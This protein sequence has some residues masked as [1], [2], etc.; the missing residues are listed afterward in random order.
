MTWWEKLFRPYWRANLAPWLHE[1]QST[2]PIVG[3]YHVY[4]DRGWQRLVQQQ[5]D[6]LRKSGLLE[7]TKQLFVSLV[8]LRE[9]DEAAFRAL[10]P[11]ANISVCSV[12]R[13]PAVYEYPA[14]RQVQQ[15]AQR[16]RCWVYYFHTKGVSYQSE[17]GQSRLFRSFTRKME[18]WREMM[19]YFI[20]DCWKVA[21]NTL[22]A[23][24]DTYG[25]YQW[26]PDGYTMFSGNFWWAASDYLSS[27]PALTEATIGNNRFYSEVW[28]YTRPHTTFSAFETVVDLYFVRLPRSLYTTDNPPFWERFCF[29]WTYN[30]R[31]LL[32][33]ALGWNYKK[34]C[35]LRFQ[36]WYLKTQSSSLHCL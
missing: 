26:P 7:A 13:N 17:E 11:E 22:E 31:K 6:H 9:E 23:G 32:K 24:H 34:R 10:A 29:C 25:C 33:H 3:V 14:L 8:C 28:L 16:Q 1:P 36:Q 15:V 2:L 5:L 35:Q 4:C 30:W 18:A 19:E 27:L 12:E 20:M 21:V